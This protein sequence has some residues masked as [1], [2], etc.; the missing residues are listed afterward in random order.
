ME[1]KADLFACDLSTYT[2]TEMPNL[3]T[4]P[5]PRYFHSCWLYGN[6]MYLYGGYSGSERLS[7]MYVYCF[8]SNHWTQVM[9]TTG[10]APSGRSSLVAQ[11]Y[12]NS[13][14]VFG[15]YNGATV[16]NDFYR[17]RLK[18]IDAPPPALV[19]DMAKLINNPESSD[20]HFLV[21]GKDVYAHKA[22]L[23]VRSK[24]FHA[25]LCSGNFREGS[26]GPDTGPQHHAPV[27]LPD[28]SYQVFMHVLEFLYT[29]TLRHVSLETG[30]H[31]LIASELYMLDRLKALCED[32]IRRGI[33]VENVI[34]ILVAAH[35]H[36]A[37]AL[38][39][40]ALEFILAHLNDSV[41]MAG[42]SELKAEPDL[43]LEII[44][45]KTATPSASHTHG[46]GMLP[47]DT[48]GPFGPTLEWNFR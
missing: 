16:L 19:S 4:P 48:N 6:S 25:M 21:E 43:L 7:D 10:D 29:D 15:G 22:I 11:I 12:Q 23:S 17:F 20:V 34:S 1:R 38:K 8:D 44:K 2:W 39:D 36:N 47:Q 31:L 42:L 3:G 28:V 5:S 24:Y 13:L 9:A 32:V 40:L 14:Y 27:E 18:P 33:S 26:A 37:S 45:R 30:I 46:G 41:V 35:R